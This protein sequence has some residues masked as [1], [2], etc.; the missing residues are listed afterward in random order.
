MT[1][2]SVRRSRSANAMATRR[3]IPAR[4][5]LTMDKARAPQ[6]REHAE[7]ASQE[8]LPDI[9][10]YVVAGMLHYCRPAEGLW[11]NLG[12]GDGG[13]GL[14]LAR[15]SGSTV[16]LIDPDSAD[17]DRR[18][19]SK[20]GQRLGAGPRHGG[21]AHS[22]QGARRRRPGGRQSLRRAVRLAEYDVRRR[23]LRA[24][25]AHSHPA[26]REP[27]P[28]LRTVGAAVRPGQAV[29]EGHEATADAG[30]GSI[31]PAAGAV[32]GRADG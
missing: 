5:S 29:F 4:S 27:A 1:P 12:S 8:P 13:I 20:R 6:G 25:P 3:V 2:V 16:V 24:R 11:V 14:E 17:V 9:Y 10:P 19:P 31:A 18:A 30:D 15:E 32:S 21:G 7:S 22:G 23:A 28:R 26:R